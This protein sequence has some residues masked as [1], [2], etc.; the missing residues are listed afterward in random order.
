MDNYTETTKH[1]V[2]DRFE[3]AVEGI[4]YSHQ[5]IYGYR[6]KYSAGSNISRYILTKSILNT[7]NKYKFESFIDIGGAEGYTAY[8]VQKLF[9]A[10]VMI[11][12]LS[13]ASCR[14]SKEIFSIEALPCDIHD[15]PFKD[16][17][18]EV[19]L[20]SETLEHVTDYKKATDELLRIT[21]KLLVITVPHES[22]EQVEENIR[23]HEPHGHI[24][25]FDTNSFNYLLEKGYEISTEKTLSPFLIIPRVIA[26]ANNKDNKKLVYKLYNTITPF[27]RKIFGKVSAMKISDS[28]KMFCNTFHKYGGITF[29]IKK[30]DIEYKVN[31]K[32]IKT[33]D[34]IDITVKEFK[35][36]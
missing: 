23:N 15:L 17:E 22:P 13:E 25:Y 14:R 19:V 3:T 18:F 30:Q 1:I 11:T 27:L 28:D 2:D 32:E 35:L 6:S 10:K 12:D 31:P 33:K 34:F 26:E 4:Y 16:E 36:N 7:L 24:H 29:T 9:G 5:P 21:K 20:C 8:L